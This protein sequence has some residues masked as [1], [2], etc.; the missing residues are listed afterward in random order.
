MYI[1]MQIMPNHRAFRPGVRIVAVVVVSVL[2]CAWGGLYTSGRT[3]LDAHADKRA[4]AQSV[5]YRGDV[6]HTGSVDGVGLAPPLVEAWSH[7]LGS[8]VSYPII[9]EGKVVVSYSEAPNGNEGTHIIAFDVVT[10]AT[11]WGPIPITAPYSNNG[12]CYDDGTIYSLPFDGQLF[13]FD[14]DTGT[15][16]WHVELPEY[17]IWSTPAARDGVVYVNAQQL[18]AVDGATGE[19]LWSNPGGVSWCAPIITDDAIYVEYACGLVIKYRKSDGLLLWRTY[20]PCSG[21]GGNPAT[22]YNN[23]VYIVDNID[24][25][26][27]LDAADGHLITTHPSFV[28]P[29]FLGSVGFYLTVDLVL[30]A[31]ELDSDTL[32]W[33]FAGDGMLNTAP[34][35]VDGV[36]YVGSGTGELTG[37][38]A[39]TG[40]LVW[41]DNVGGPFYYNET[42]GVGILQGI[43]A[44]DG[45]LVVP[46]GNRLIA[47]KSASAVSADCPPDIR[48]TAGATNGCARGAMVTFPPPTVD[49]PFCDTP[50][51]VCSPA[52]GS[53]L[54]EGTYQ[55]RCTA[56]DTCGNT[57]RC[58][59][60]ITVDPAITAASSVCVMDDATGDRFSEVVDSTSGL[61]GYWTYF[62]ASTGET[63]CGRANRVAYA[64]GRSL[65]S[66]DS[67]GT[68]GTTMS[69]QIR[70]GGAATIRIR[71]A[72]GRSYY[73]R[74]RNTADDPQCG[75]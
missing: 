44:G 6:A 38:D 19:I 51:I 28:S 71:S 54:A 60:T 29:T 1:P 59:F 42:P 69:A 58:G 12:L 11:A 22:F 9:A 5:A 18:H 48:V 53:F 13:A 46:V 7:D 66:S 23:R 21:G 2:V 34:V 43:G 52:S 70:I 74:D 57:G 65:V 32:L 50:T 17:F 24:G 73:L 47:Y 45:L 40:Q 56:T 20:P 61:Y 25:N 3:R 39:V 49:G 36:V 26:D 27:V 30:E 10:G 55:V 14:I 75:T 37:L 64:A 8:T 62:V 67:D 41:S 16:K 63:I 72:S 15:L 33:S 35:C 31:R 4:A 68:D